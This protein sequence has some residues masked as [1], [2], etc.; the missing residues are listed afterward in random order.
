MFSC[1]W[2]QVEGR[3]AQWLATKRYDIS[4]CSQHKLEREWRYINPGF[5]NFYEW[6]TVPHLSL[7]TYYYIVVADLHVKFHVM[8]SGKNGEIVSIRMSQQLQWW[9]FV[10]IQIDFLK[11]IGILK[12]ISFS[13]LL[14]TVYAR[15][16]SP[17]SICG[18]NHFD[19]RFPFGIEGQN[20]SYPGF[21]LRCSNQGRSILSLPGAGDYYVR[22][23]APK[24]YNSTIH[25]IASQNGWSISTLPSS[26]FKVKWHRLSKQFHYFNFSYLFYKCCKPNDN[27]AY[28]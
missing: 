1:S 27:F 2:S 4:L 15:H 5:R 18:N 14:L 21:S 16:D 23:T 28:L 19:I 11:Y 10:H 22:D 9:R 6:Q 8:K 13:F 26:P 24:K 7:I 20:C 17:T 12:L 25:L 3:K